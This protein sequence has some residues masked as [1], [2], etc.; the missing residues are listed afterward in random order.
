MELNTDNYIGINAFGAQV[1]VT[2]TGL[3]KPLKAIGRGVKAVFGLSRSNVNK[4]AK[5]LAA[6]TE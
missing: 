3:D 1:G 6:K 4:A 2:V 5:F